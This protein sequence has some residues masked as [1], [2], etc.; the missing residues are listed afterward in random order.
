MDSNFK[1]VGMAIIYETS[2]WKPVGLQF[3]SCISRYIFS[4]VYWVK[5]V[6]VSK[7]CIIS[8]VSSKFCTLG[9]LL[10]PMLGCNKNCVYNSHHYQLELENRNEKRSKWT[11][12]SNPQFLVLLTFSHW[13][14][15]HLELGIL[16]ARSRIHILL[17]S[18]LKKDVKFWNG[19]KVYGYKRS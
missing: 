2:G 19:R 17:D 9:T 12:I 4:I 7:L 14:M 1:K 18:L 13:K 10:H 5:L 3:K 16:N 11:C 8:S 6:S 15:V